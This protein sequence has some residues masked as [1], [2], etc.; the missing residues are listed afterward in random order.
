MRCPFCKHENDK[1]ID[2]RTADEGLAIRRRRE[3]VNC[4]RRY[5]TYERLEEISLYLIKKDQ[6][7]EPYDRKKAL[8]GVMKAC[9][10]RPV[11]LADQEKIIDDMEKF[12]HEKYE[13][14]VPS[15]AVGEF[16]MKRLAKVDQVAYVRFASVYREFQDVSHFMKELKS[17]LAKGERQPV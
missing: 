14:E 13:K 10:K 1:V 11:S 12:L 8:D 5:T 2:S 16:I 17:L 6:R 7:R 9:G 15:S 4:N 3:C